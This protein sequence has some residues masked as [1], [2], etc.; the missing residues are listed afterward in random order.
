M[1]LLPKK[2][3]K[4]NQIENVD[5]LKRVKENQISI[6]EDD[7]ITAN[8]GS[9]IILDFGKETNGGIRILSYE[10]A[11]KALKVRI[12]FGESV[13]ET[14]AE[15]GE[16]NATN[17]HSPRDME[18]LLPCYSDL[19]FGN[20]GFR[21][22]RIDFLE[23]GRFTIKSILA[24][25]RILKKRANYTYCGTDPE[26]K[27]IFKVAKRTIDLCAAE[28]YL[29]D[30]IKRDRL[31]WI[32]DIHPEMLAF[33]TLYGKSPII[34][35][36]LDFIRKKTPLPKFMN[37]YSTYSL[38]WII[39]LWDYYKITGCKKYLTE[40][41]AYLQ[42]LLKVI[43]EN[44]ADSGEILYD[45]IFVEWSAC[46][47]EDECL[48][49]KLINIYAVKCAKE[50]LALF[51]EDV[52]LCNH[53][54]M[55]LQKNDFTVNGQKSVIA[56]KYFA[57]GE[58][59][60]R[61]YE[62]LIKG[63]SSGFSTFMSYYILSTIAAFDK[64]KAIDLLKEY[65]GAMLKKGATTFWE[66]FDISWVENSGTICAFPKKG[67]KDIH[68]DF[69]KYCYEGFRHSLCHGWSSGIIKFIKDNCK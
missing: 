58:I 60:G 11:K 14:C 13:S 61:E 41:C 32:G 39:I 21:F 50:I 20:T 3:I 10:V 35:N 5:A 4:Y 51:G 25:E 30:G 59:S 63:N 26:I 18:C 49:A 23:E 62:M 67:Q 16:K 57:L 33:T 46:G 44:V 45:R 38:W 47:T 69:G 36:S 17:D 27:K 54:L 15:I 22:V 19:T 8:K 31:V 65:Y 56:L 42:G 1:Y 52:A 7:Y 6:L 24:Q 28:G 64:E 34:E 66:D 37:N 48:G 12:R 40:Q 53:I 55:K 68:G 43:D 29:W 9:Y 2:I